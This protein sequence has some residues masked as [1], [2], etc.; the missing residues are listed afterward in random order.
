MNGEETLENPADETVG[1]DWEIGETKIWDY[2][3]PRGNC[4]IVGKC[5]RIRK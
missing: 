4:A 2:R 5:R 3:K 1:N